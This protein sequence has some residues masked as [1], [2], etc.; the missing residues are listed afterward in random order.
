MIVKEKGTYEN[1]KRFLAT[2][3]AVLMA[4]GSCAFAESG[5]KWTETKWR[6][7]GEGET[8]MNQPLAILLNQA[9]QFLRLTAMH[10]RT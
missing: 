2:L 7:V 6:M 1:F 3:L 4:L 10:L 5:A 9:L 8:R